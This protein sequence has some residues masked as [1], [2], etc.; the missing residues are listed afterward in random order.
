M[1]LTT[2]IQARAFLDALHL[3]E[4]DLPAFLAQLERIALIRR[5]EEAS[6]IDE[7]LRLLREH[8]RTRGRTEC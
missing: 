3:S 1:N 7:L 4:V 6:H 8:E 2:S 5:P